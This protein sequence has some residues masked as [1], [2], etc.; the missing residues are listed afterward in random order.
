M[1]PIS[2]KRTYEKDTVT[3]ADFN[4]FA[5]K[6]QV[7]SGKGGGFCVLVR[8]RAAFPSLHTVRDAFHSCKQQNV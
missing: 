8:K 6:L 4:L 2:G 1:T 5:I 3:W 7:G